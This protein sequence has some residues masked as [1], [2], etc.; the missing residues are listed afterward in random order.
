MHQIFEDNYSCYGVRKM[1]AA[2]NREGHLGHVA[3]CTVER[4]MAIEGLRGIR[5]R[6]KKPS[7]RSADAGDC[8]VD[9]VD[10][11][12]EVEAPNKLWVG[13]HYLYLDLAGLGVCR[14]CVGCVFTRDRR[15]ADHQSHACIPS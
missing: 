2:I 1:W 12:F 3:R 15:L 5:R 6:K 10:R 9:L 13:R 14:F 11:N 4:L 8:P 7:T